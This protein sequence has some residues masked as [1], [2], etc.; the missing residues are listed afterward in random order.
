MNACVRHHTSA[1]TKR[2]KFYSQLAADGPKTKANKRAMTMKATIKTEL[3]SQMKDLRRQQKK[4]S[5]F[6]LIELMIVVAII[7]ILAAIAIPQYQAYTGRAQAAEGITLFSGIKTSLGEWWNE[8]GR[9]PNST[10]DAACL[11]TGGCNPAV[12]VAPAADITGSYVSTV[13][14]AN[15]GVVTVTFGSDSVHN[16]KTLLFTPTSNTG[17][18]EW[19]CST[20]TGAA[21]ITASYL[22]STCR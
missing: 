15:T 20:G 14:L 18:L 17:T 8:K 9:W 5:G 16:G 19:T 7:G 13:D 12:G 3:Q 22:P 10:D 11:A 2:F 1:K 6:T 21:A 4:Q